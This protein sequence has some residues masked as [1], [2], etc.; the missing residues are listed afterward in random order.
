MIGIQISS[1]RKEDMT[2]ITCHRTIQGIPSTPCE[3]ILCM[4]KC[5]QLTWCPLGL[6][7]DLY[8]TQLG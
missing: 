1:M 3:P 8:I 5:A 2:Q 4:L 6:Q 7:T